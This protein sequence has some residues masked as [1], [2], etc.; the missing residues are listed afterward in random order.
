MKNIFKLLTAFPHLLMNCSLL[1]L[2][3]GNRGKVTLS[4]L[5]KQLRSREC[6]SNLRSYS[7]SVGKPESISGHLILSMCYFFRE[8]SVSEGLACLKARGGF[9]KTQISE[10]HP[11]IVNSV[12]L[13]GPP[14][15]A[16]PVS[17]QVMLL[18]LVLGPHFESHSLTS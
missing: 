11:H 4:F 7:W 10:S 13:G 17:S 12:G 18:L 9:I 6:V 16:F 2:R 8:I 15:S 3:M 14:R 5:I 1:I